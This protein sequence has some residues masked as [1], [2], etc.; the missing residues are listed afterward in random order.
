MSMN[1]HTVTRKIDGKG[2][3]VIVDDEARKGALVAGYGYYLSRLCDGSTTT[4]PQYF[5]DRESAR[6]AMRRYN[7]LNEGEYQL[8]GGLH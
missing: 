6:D 7:E 3:I 8:V 5:P 4:K 1:I 2:W